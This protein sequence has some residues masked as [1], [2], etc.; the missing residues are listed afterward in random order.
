[1]KKLLSLV[2]LLSG[3]GVASY[4]QENQ[5]PEV[6]RNK[7]KCEK[8][9]HR[10]ANKSPE[11]L[12]KIKTERLD[13]ELKFTDEQ[14]SQVYAIQL[15]EAKR[16]AES[17]AKMGELRKEQR[18]AMEENKEKMGEILTAEQQTQL[19]EKFAHVKKDKRMHRRGDF[20]MR[21]DRFERQKDTIEKKT[22]MRDFIV[23][24]YV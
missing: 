9:G 21:K 11:E 16:Q 4:A 5:D 1:M 13:K 14:R 18:E 7:G 8:M 24:L 10:M 3:L 15:D 20:K 2:V 12:A 17:R 22:M 19:K 23:R 6:T